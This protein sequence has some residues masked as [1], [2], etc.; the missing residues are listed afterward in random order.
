VFGINWWWTATRRLL[1]SLTAVILVLSL[2]SCGDRISELPNSSDHSA[3]IRVK[4]PKISEVS[5]TD[6]IQELRQALE[7]YQPQVKILSPQPGEVLKDN[8]VTVKFDVQD[9]PIF[10]DANLGLGPHLHLFLDNQD[11]QAIYDTNKPLVLS[12]LEPGT[13]TL[14]A[15][16][17][18]PWHESFKNEGA[19]AEITFHVFT[20]T[21]ENNPD[22]ALPLLTYSR[23]QGSYGAEPIMLDFYLTN[24][25]LHSVAQENPDD[26]IF[27]WKIRVTVNGES[28]LVDEWE[29]IYLKGF[30]PGKNWV[31][32]ELID[33]QGNPIQNVFNNT[34][35]VITY[36][37]DGEDT[38]SKLVRGELTAADAGG[39]VDPNYVAKKPEPIPEPVVIPEPV[40]VPTPVVIPEPVE[41][42][43]PVVIPEPV[44]VPTTVVT[45]EPVEVPTTVV[46]PEA[47]DAPTLPEVEQ[48]PVS[49]A[50]EPTVKVESPQILP[51]PA[52]VK[53]ENAG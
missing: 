37:P 21:Q 3:T 40:E 48:A 30:N 24:A 4:A 45:P 19:F 27:D 36:Q 34:V 35:R 8:T 6:A 22:P 52:A 15:F 20:K 17:S 51:T 43:T 50:A 11:Y 2:A 28:F 26:R 41:V 47:V 9:F 13:H 42:P 16:A 25:P 7:I 23:P 5:P 49:E 18:R 53:S 44:E 32:V 33:E 14:R 31:Q 1:A 10:K 46:K 12:D 39:I 29:P 38:L